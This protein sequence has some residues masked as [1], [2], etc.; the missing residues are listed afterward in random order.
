MYSNQEASGEDMRYEILNTV[1]EYIEQLKDF[2]RVANDSLY[3]PQSSTF[4]P[5][6][7]TISKEIDSLASDTLS[8]IFSDEIDY[9]EGSVVSWYEVYSEGSSSTTGS[10]IT[11]ESPSLTDLNSVCLGSASLRHT[12][13]K[14][15]QNLMHGNRN[16]G[17]AT[18]KWLDVAKLIEAMNGSVKS[19]G[20]SIKMIHIPGNN[21]IPNRPTR[22]D[23]P[24][25]DDR[26]GLSKAITIR[27]IFKKWGISCL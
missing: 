3:S 20:G 15:L 1:A 4:I 7:V 23:E 13:D 26:L 8:P 16:T 19:I 10:S 12:H 17:L 25:P 5:K 9:S 27:K 14:T 24:H 22:F 2:M 18:I 11:D 6:D 21:G